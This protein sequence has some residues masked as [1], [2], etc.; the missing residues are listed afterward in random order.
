MLTTIKY[1]P[2]DFCTP[3]MFK[4][5]Q[6]ILKESLMQETIQPLKKGGG[7]KPGAN[8]APL[9]TCKHFTLLVITA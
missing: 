8:S 9:E 7:L 5:I 1:Q 4:T 6:I 3:S 2:Q